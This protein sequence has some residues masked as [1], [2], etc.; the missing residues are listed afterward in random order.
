MLLNR[1]FRFSAKHLSSGSIMKEVQKIGTHDGAF[2]CD[3]VLACAMLKHLPQFKDAEIV[4]TRDQ[5]KLDQC[6]IVVDVGGTYDPAK[7]R[8]V[9]TKLCSRTCRI[10]SFFA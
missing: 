10:T 4:R 3:E 9:P 2:H 7:H 5:S 6:D 8:F 1:L